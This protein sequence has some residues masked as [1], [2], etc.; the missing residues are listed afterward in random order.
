METRTKRAAR[1]YADVVIAIVVSVGVA[2]VLSAP[3]GA[4]I[5]EDVATALGCALI[6]GAGIMIALCFESCRRGAE[7]FSTR[8]LPTCEN[9]AF[10]FPTHGNPTFELPTREAPAEP[11]RCSTKASSKLRRSILIGCCLASAIL[12]AVISMP[13]ESA[14]IFEAPAAD[15][16]SLAA[17]ALI[18][19]ATGCSEEG[20]FR[21]LLP[22]AFK[23][24]FLANGHDTRFAARAATLLSTLLFAF[25]HVDLGVLPASLLEGASMVLKFAQAALFGLAMA[26]LV[27]TP[28]G[29]VAAIIVHACYDL[30]ASAPSV[31]SSGWLPNS[32]L[33]DDPLGIAA[34]TAA[35]AALVPAAITGWGIREKKGDD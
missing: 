16:K 1:R 11:E 25:L 27:R 6:V 12:F 4:S 34:L 32:Y 23:K 15:S 22:R 30:F 35:S 8:E 21:F 17:F 3:T 14:A 33:T 13:A 31:W 10:E 2:A 24:G 29:L 28:K 5:A 18:C 26:G 20:L 19:L 9:P 7:E